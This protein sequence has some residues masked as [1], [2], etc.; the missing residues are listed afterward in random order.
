MGRVVLLS[1]VAMMGLLASCNSAGDVSG[2]GQVFV[3]KPSFTLDCQ[4][5]PEI[6]AQIR[7]GIEAALAHPNTMCSETAQRA[8]GRFEAPPGEGFRDR[9]QEQDYMMSV[10]MTSPTSFTPLDGYTNV[11]PGFW[12][13]GLSPIQVGALV[14]HEE[15]HH[16]GSDSQQHVTGEAEKYQQACLNPDA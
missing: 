14:V 7:E 11:Y 15:K 1:G 13:A 6:C 8:L 2:P 9:S 3:G 5:G 10:D 16:D 4:L 12:G